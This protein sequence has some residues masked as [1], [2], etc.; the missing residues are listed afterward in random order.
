[1]TAPLTSSTPRP[2]F[3]IAMASFM[4]AVTLTGFAGTFIA[5]KNRHS[6]ES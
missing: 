2:R 1:M 6:R 5:P 3:Y 4:L